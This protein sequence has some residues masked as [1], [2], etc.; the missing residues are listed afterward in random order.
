MV[1]KILIDDPIL[2]KK[3]RNAMKVEVDFKKLVPRMVEAVKA[4]G[5]NGFGIAAVQIGILLR[6]SVYNLDPKEYS[7][8]WTVLFNPEIVET[9]ESCVKLNEG[10]L[11][12]PGIRF[13]TKRFDRIV[14]KNYNPDIGK[15]ELNMCRGI[16]AQIVQHEVDHMD[17]ILIHD[18]QYKPSQGRNEP[19]AC[20][21][22]KKFKV[23]CG[24]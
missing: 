13:N 16:E 19:C 4:Q 2:R 14:V 7:Q 17:G 15:Y 23:C 5:T 9:F 21:S 10:C 20:G 12:L 6:V 3:S 11:S 18:R 1:D 8:P 22:G 24:R